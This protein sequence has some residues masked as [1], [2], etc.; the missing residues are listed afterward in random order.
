[1]QTL[2]E[3]ELGLTYEAN[4]PEIAHVN[5]TIEL[6]RYLSNILT[7]AIRNPNWMRTYLLDNPYC[8]WGS[9]YN[10][11]LLGDDSWVISGHIKR[12]PKFE[13]GVTLEQVFH[14]LETIPNG[15]H[16]VCHIHPIYIGWSDRVS[17]E[18]NLSTTVR[19]DIIALQNSI[20]ILQNQQE[21]VKNT[22]TNVIETTSD[23]FTDSIS[24]LFKQQAL[25]QQELPDISQKIQDFQKQIE[26]TH[27]EL[28]IQKQ[29]LNIILADVNRPRGYAAGVKTDIKEMKR[30]LKAKF[31][32]FKA[33][34]INIGRLASLPIKALLLSAHCLRAIIG[35]KKRTQ[36]LHNHRVL[37]LTISQIDVDPRINK[38]ART[39]VEN[40]YE[41]DIFCHLLRPDVNQVIIDEIQ[42]GIRYI[43]IP[44]N[45][46]W[47]GAQIGIFYQEAF[48]QVGLRWDYDYVHSNDLTSLLVGWL[49]ARAQGVPFIYDAHELWSENVSLNSRREWVPMSDR[50][51]TWSRYFEGFLTSYADLFLTVSPSIQAEYQK[52]YNLSEPPV[53]LANF[54]E[55]SLLDNGETSANEI[56]SV[57]ETCSLSDEHFITL[58]LGG[59]N[60][61]RNIENVIRAHQYLPEQCIFV[62]RGPGIEQFCQ[63]YQ[64]LAQEL[65]LE[66][67]VIC[68]PPVS[69]ADIV[70]A[71]AGANCGIVMLRNICLNFYWFYPNKFFEYMLSG[72]PVAVSNFPDVSAHI[73]REQC[74]VVFD[75]DSPESIADALRYLYQNPD[76]ARA[77][78]DRGQAGIL[79][80]YNWEQGAQDL[81]T[82][83]KNLYDKHGT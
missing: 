66:D 2:N 67:R 1:M 12:D 64:A 46:W 24:Q 81:I 27:S 34:M 50:A 17:R 19:Q 80:E 5:N 15:K 7:D 51:R 30:A 28:L 38:V 20:N 8:R 60:T 49:L 83:Y 39:L 10:L 35:T 32:Q 11:W 23:A 62:I 61:L 77:M 18:K 70:A 65:G 37:M 63:Q 3:T 9:D 21:N 57:R 48:R 76:E 16:V 36:P 40:G 53:M 69:M 31:D 74:G 25:V 33:R 75:P 14:F 71:S 58:Y 82:E 6:N 41:V 56:P 47:R 43:R 42:S 79:R 22:L 45:R 59:V 73:E 72:L 13:W 26:L 4:W 29:Q 54:P 68:L 44:K 55:L 52:R 78:G